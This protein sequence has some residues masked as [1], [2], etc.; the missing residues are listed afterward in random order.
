MRRGLRDVP[1]RTKLRAL[2]LL[3]SGVALVVGLGSFLAY[4]AASHRQFALRNL[5]VLSAVARDQLAPAL[6]SG[7]AR[8]ASEI[9]ESIEGE[10]EVLA[11]AVYGVRGGWNACRSRRL[12]TKSCG[13]WRRKSGSGGPT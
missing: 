12:Y 10:P 1:I 9:L 7:D 6:E 5:E 2:F 3:T 4:D 11:A 13:T 8:A